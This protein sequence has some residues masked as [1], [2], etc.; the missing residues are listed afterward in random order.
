MDDDKQW[1]EL[2]QKFRVVHRDTGD[3]VRE[4]FV[5]VPR[6]DLSGWIAAMVYATICEPSLGAKLERELRRIWREG[7]VPGQ[8]GRVNKPHARAGRDALR[9]FK[10]A[11]RAQRAGYGSAVQQA[12]ELLE[13]TVDGAPQ[14]V[15]QDEAQG[16]ELE[17]L[18]AAVT[19]ELQ[20]FPSGETLTAEHVARMVRSQDPVAVDRA[21]CTMAQ[22]GHLVERFGMMTYKRR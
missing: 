11:I 22:R 1:V 17:R 2:G 12:Q 21:L 15:D 9:L 7:L 13:R 20:G 14:E 19:A 10:A 3:A 5:L 6:R 16:D 18:I 4:P 8:Q